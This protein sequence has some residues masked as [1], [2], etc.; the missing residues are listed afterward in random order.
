M[1]RLLDHRQLHGHAFQILDESMHFILR[2]IPV[3]G[4]FESGKLERQDV[5]FRPSSY[6]PPLRVSH[7]LTDRQRE[8]LQILGD[9]Q[10]WRF[11]DVLAR[12]SAPPAPR[13]LRDD[14]QMLKK[15]ALV[16]SGGRSVAARWW[17]VTPD[18]PV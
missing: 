3:A 6:H 2:N 5:R 15:L 18:L 11:Q 10:R 4:R 12:L 16:N 14:L 8:V 9:G 7:D 13:T 1:R 17:L